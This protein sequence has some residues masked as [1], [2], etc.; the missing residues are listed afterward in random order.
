MDLPKTEPKSS[1]RTKRFYL[2]FGIAL[3]FTSFILFSLK[4]T[5]S[6]FGRHV[7]YGFMT[8]ILAIGFI[9]K[10]YDD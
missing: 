5:V 7:G 10:S 6:I 1:T 8:F 9:Y 2:I 4:L 3:V